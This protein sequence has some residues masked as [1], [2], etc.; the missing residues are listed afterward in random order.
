MQA[1]YFSKKFAA[2]LPYDRYV[3]TG[4]DE[5]K[6]RWQQVY[7]A[8]K[9]TA[10]QKSLVGGF[11][12]EM[13][14]L[15]ISGIWCG[16]CVQQCPLI[17]RIAE[18]NAAKISLRI[19]DRDEHRDLADAFRINAGDR[20]PVALFLAEDFEFCRRVRR[21]D[22]QPLPRAGPAIFRRGVSHGHRQSRQG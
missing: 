19:L 21:P 16:D 3:Q 2:A 17:A 20:V 13:N 10:A 12:R 9:L 4:T 1:E 7:D 11:V 14:V 15:I 22:D 18:A 6:R 8:A 5:Q